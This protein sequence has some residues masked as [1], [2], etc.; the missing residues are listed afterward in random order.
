M[1]SELKSPLIMR[2][3]LCTVAFVSLATPGRPA[4]VSQRTEGPCSPAIADVKGNVN[5]ECRGVDQ[6]IADDIIKMLN[7]IL[8]DTRKL[9]VI[10]RELERTSKRTDEIEVRLGPRRL[11]PNQ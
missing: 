2:I 7:E 3:G 5:I 6:K 4:T 8:Q 10:R 1:I 9:E 11:T